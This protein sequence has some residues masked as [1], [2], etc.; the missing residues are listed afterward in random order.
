MN[1]HFLNAEFKYEEP[2][3]KRVIDTATNYINGAIQDLNIQKPFDVTMYPNH[4]WTEETDGVDG[5]AFSGGLLQLRIDLRN[6]KNKIDDLL[7]DPLKATIYHEC[8]HIL[9]W[10]SV[11]Y[12]TSLIEATISEG[13]ATSYEKMIC[14]PYVIKHADHSNIEELL[15]YYRERNKD[16]DTTYNHW[17]WFFGTHNKY[18]RWLGYKVGSYIVD[19]AMKNKPSMT[20]TEITKMSA[21]E[22]LAISNISI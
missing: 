3:V 17:E 9:R 18:P 5:E 2:L 15:K 22:I 8:N 1:I 19:E 12:G 7:G 4:A 11:G 14:A 20:F 6:E 16:E 21:E 10:Q 13:I